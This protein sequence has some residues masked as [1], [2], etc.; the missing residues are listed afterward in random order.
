MLT[1]YFWSSL[2][3]IIAVIVVINRKQTV[4]IA[5]FAGHVLASL[6]VTY[7][8]WDVGRNVIETIHDKATALD[9]M[10]D[11]RIL[12]FAINAGAVFIA[13][14]IVWIL[15]IAVIWITTAYIAQWLQHQVPGA[16]TIRTATFFKLVYVLT[17][18][19]G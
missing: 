10:R 18:G 17:R 13:V 3:V 11:T 16:S 1:P 14:C 6:A 2:L 8:A 7:Y 5:L 4:M 19:K 12:Y 15:L 9:A